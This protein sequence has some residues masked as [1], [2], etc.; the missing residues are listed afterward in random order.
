MLFRAAVSYFAMHFVGSALALA[1]GAAPALPPQTTLP[2]TF[3]HTISS[4]H[5]HEGDAIQAKISAPVRLPDGVTL[6]AGAVLTGRVVRAEPFLYDKTPYAKQKPGALAI[7][8]DSVDEHGTAIPLHVTTRALADP[9]VVDDT[10]KPLPTD[11]DA[12]HTTTQVGGDQVTPFVKE[13]RN[14]DGDV[15]GY[16]HGG[17]AYAHPLAGP[18][19]DGIDTEQ[20]M[21]VFSA[22]ACG[23]YGFQGTSMTQDTGSGASMTLISTHRS[24]EISAHSSAL[25]VQG[26]APAQTASR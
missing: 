9:L 4:A 7:R 5:A 26:D 10:Q 13:I 16:L 3:P 12:T 24:P 20:A 14:G 2:V 18:G 11:I 21:G 15:V 8:F 6:P 1:Q 22:S 19:C 25:L 17:H 23:L